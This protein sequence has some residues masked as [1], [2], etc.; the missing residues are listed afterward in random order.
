MT[1]CARFGA[2]RRGWSRPGDQ[3]ICFC[4][5]GTWRR[6]ARQPNA[7]TLRRPDAP[8]RCRENNAYTARRLTQRNFSA[9][10]GLARRWQHAQEYRTQFQLLSPTCAVLREALLSHEPWMMETLEC[11]AKREQAARVP[12]HLVTAQIV[13]APSSEPPARS[14][15]A[16]P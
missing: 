6:C 9:L 10:S 2:D 1:G 5:A 13:A 16:R 11:D 15:P 14:E 12:L 8:S 7:S 3:A 4:H